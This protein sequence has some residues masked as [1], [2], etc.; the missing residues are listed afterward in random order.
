M[1]II[2]KVISKREKFQEAHK[3]KQTSAGRIP[4]CWLF[5]YGDD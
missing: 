5:V 3:K 2:G 4:L 1:G